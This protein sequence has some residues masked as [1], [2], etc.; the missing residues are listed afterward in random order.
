MKII[1]EILIDI[2]IIFMAIVVLL[3][4]LIII[5]KLAERCKK[6]KGNINECYVIYE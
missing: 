6:E 5:N 3:I 1:K 2:L 4:S